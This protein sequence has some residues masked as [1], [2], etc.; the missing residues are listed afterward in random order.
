M[1]P[2]IV[3]E[4]DRYDE[5]GRGSTPQ[6]PH[7]AHEY[8]THYVSAPASNPFIGVRSEQMCEPMLTA[9]PRGETQSN[10]AKR[11]RQADKHHSDTQSLA[12]MN[13]IYAHDGET[14]TSLF[15]YKVL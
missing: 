10:V 4:L 1:L 6:S 3:A 5:W 15:E 11:E 7:L 13:S 14:L 12:T 9:W 2:G 8:L